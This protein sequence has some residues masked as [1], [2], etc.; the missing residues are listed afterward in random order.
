MGLDLLILLA[1]NKRDMYK[2][3][4]GHLDKSFVVL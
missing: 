1:F 2:L 4:G 3:V